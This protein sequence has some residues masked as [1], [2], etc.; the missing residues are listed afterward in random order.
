MS[1]Y[2]RYKQMIEK[3]GATWGYRLEWRS[4]DEDTDP[5]RPQASIG[6]FRALEDDDSEGILSDT[7]GV[8]VLSVVGGPQYNNERVALHFYEDGMDEMTGEVADLDNFEEV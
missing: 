7:E 5:P 3:W 6:R 4:D 8:I 2:D 1:D